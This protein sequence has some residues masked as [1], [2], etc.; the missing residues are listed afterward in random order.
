MNDFDTLEAFVLDFLAYRR[1]RRK[2]VT[3]Q[4]TPSKMLTAT[5]PSP[6]IPPEIG[7]GWPYYRGM[8]KP[9]A[10]QVEKTPTSTIPS[11]ERDFIIPTLE[12]IALA[13]IDKFGTPQNQQA[14]THLIHQV[15]AKAMALPPVAES[16]RTKEALVPWGRAALM[17]AVVELLIRFHGDPPS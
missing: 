4:E 12:P 17:T 14:R 1:Q 11:S 5:S 13:M 15:L 7:R 8:L 16:M 9:E 3:V 6:D 10:A 2:G